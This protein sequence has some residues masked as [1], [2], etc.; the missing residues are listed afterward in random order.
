VLA[1]APNSL[2]ALDRTNRAAATWYAQWAAPV[3]GRV[4]R[5][6]RIPAAELDRGT[7]MFDQVRLDYTTYITLER[8]A[9]ARLRS[10]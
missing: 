6:E 10:S 8:V 7:S 1:D 4:R 5:G 2:Q 9:R 3:L